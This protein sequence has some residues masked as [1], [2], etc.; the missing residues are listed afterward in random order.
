MPITLE[1]DMDDPT[2]KIKE[3]YQVTARGRYAQAY[4]LWQTAYGSNASS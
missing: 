4:G 3:R 2:A 1:T